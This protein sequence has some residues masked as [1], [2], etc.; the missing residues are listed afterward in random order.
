MAVLMDN[1]LHCGIST[2]MHLEACGLQPVV[3]A[4][5]VAAGF[6]QVQRGKD[7]RDLEKRK[8]AASAGIPLKAA[9]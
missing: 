6:A 2:Q 3:I 4:S 8:Q 1:Y 5:R 9:A 7:G